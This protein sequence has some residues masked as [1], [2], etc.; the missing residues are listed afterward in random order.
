MLIAL[1]KLEA[2]GRRQ[3]GRRFGLFLPFIGGG[4]PPVRRFQETRQKAEGSKAEGKRIWLVSSLRRGWQSPPVGRLLRNKAGGRRQEAEGRRQKA[5][6]EES[7]AC[8][9]P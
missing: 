5:P 7:L 8:L 6:R 2:G 9:F 4:T 1:E 3:E